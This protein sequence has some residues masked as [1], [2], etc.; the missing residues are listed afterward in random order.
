MQLNAGTWLEYFANNQKDR[1]EPDWK[2]PVNV[3]ETAR[4]ALYQSLREF[5]LGDGGGPASLIAFNAEVF[6]SQSEAT[7]QI[8][9]CWFE[10]EKEHSRLL[11]GLLARFSVPSIDHHWS[12]SLFCFLR[13]VLGVAFELQILTLTELVSTSYYSLL[14]KH[15][16]DTAVKEVCAL[17]LRDEFGHVRFHNARLAADGK[18]RSCGVNRLWR[19][20]FWCCGF[21]S[22]SVLWVS[23]GRCIKLLGGSTGEFYRNVAL[24]IGRFLYLL[25][26]QEEAKQLRWSVAQVSDQRL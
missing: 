25:A 6:R 7:R 9:D 26:R 11:G 21:A 4:S 22:A 17:I 5:Q 20:Q 13:R 14:R 12:F 2:A 8:V 15:C 19:A 1:I 24:Q 18:G 3:P 10:E 16:P 23:H